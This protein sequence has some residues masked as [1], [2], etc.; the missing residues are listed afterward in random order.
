M[1]C[2]HV[3]PAC[4]RHVRANE[5]ACPF[6]ALVLPADFSVCARAT[7][8]PPSRPLTRASLVL[9]GATALAAC[10]KSTGAPTGPP[11]VQGDAGA[12]PIEMPVAVYGP[13]PVAD[14]GEPPIVPQPE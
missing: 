7:R 1:S 2:L 5:P 8:P 4:S 13:A 10:G 3:C 11:A 6:C 9:M 14:A 12:G